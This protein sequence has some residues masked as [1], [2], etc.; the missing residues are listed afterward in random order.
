MRYGIRVLDRNEGWWSF[1]HS[2]QNS[3][4]RLMPRWKVIGLF[5]LFCAWGTLSGQEL[6]LELQQIDSNS[7]TSNYPRISAV[8]DRNFEDSRFQQRIP[9]RYGTR[10]YSV[11]KR[12]G[13]TVPY[14]QAKAS[15]LVFHG[16]QPVW[17]L[18]IVGFKNFQVDWVTEDV[19]KVESWPTSTLQLVELINLKSGEV[20]Y[21]S[22]TRHA[23]GKL[24]P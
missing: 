8:N 19:L 16:K 17:E 1:G 7:F 14:E 20:I 21:R 5:V 11:A 3:A 9:T 23:S 24:T 22:A 6:P 10:A 4:M 18:E 12:A 13:G 15:V 2:V